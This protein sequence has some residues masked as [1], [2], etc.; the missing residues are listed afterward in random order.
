MHTAVAVLRMLNVGFHRLLQ[1]QLHIAA[2]ADVG[3]ID[4]VVLLLQLTGIHFGD[5]SLLSV[6][7]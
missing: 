2:D 7:L 3:G 5:G 1:Q 4:A 6:Q